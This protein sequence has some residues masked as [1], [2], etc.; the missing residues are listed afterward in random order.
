MLE[1]SEDR[2]N[3]RSSLSTDKVKAFCE[4]FIRSNELFSFVPY[5]VRNTDP[6]FSRVP[7]DH[8]DRLSTL[9]TYWIKE[10]QKRQD[11]ETSAK[12]QDEPGKSETDGGNQ[13]NF[14]PEFEKMMKIV[15][16]LLEKNRKPAPGNTGPGESSPT[17]TIRPPSSPDQ[18]DE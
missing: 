11:E 13:S 7:A 12:Q 16:G 4:S 1:E 18:K 2:L 15:E 3:G 5:I 17:L 6:Y 14:G 10:T 9:K 8:E